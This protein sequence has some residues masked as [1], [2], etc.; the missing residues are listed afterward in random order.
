MNPKAYCITHGMTTAQFVDA[1]REVAPKYSKVTHCMA[2]DPAYG[3]VLRSDVARHIRGKDE[4]RAKPCKFTFR[5][6]TCDSDEFNSA[7]AIMGHSIQDATEYAVRLYIA[8]AKE[9]AATSAATLM[10]AEG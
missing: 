10:T 1:A 6:K 5:L 3:V 2:S 7:R 8:A 4:H 9:R